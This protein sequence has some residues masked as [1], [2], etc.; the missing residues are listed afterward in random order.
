MGSF[1]VVL[2]EAQN[3]DKWSSQ[4]HVTTGDPQ[5]LGGN[6]SVLSANFIMYKGIVPADTIRW[7]F[8]LD[9]RVSC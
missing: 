5:R 1:T 7:N 9:F 6:F 2:T 8:E 4:T 3:G